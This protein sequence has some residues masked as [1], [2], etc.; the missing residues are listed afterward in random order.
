M[1]DKATALAKVLPVDAPPVRVA[2]VAIADA[3]RA[4]RGYSG[5][6]ICGINP[7]PAGNTAATCT[8]VCMVCGN[9]RNSNGVFQHGHMLIDASR[10]C[11]R[12]NRS[13]GADVLG[14]QNL[15][16]P[17]TSQQSPPQRSGQGRPLT[18]AVPS[19]TRRAKIA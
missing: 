10:S 3:A 8:G 13:D 17:S 18:R 14:L 1:L 5:C 4:L 16:R 12:R 7:A 6:Y 15:P 19:A 2:G 9:T 11:P